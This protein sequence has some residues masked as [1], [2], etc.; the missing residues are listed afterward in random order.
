MH[1]L[2]R[3][4]SSCLAL[5]LSTRH[6]PERVRV[7]IVF[8]ISATNT[9]TARASFEA[10]AGV[11]PPAQDYNEYRLHSEATGTPLV[12]NWTLTCMGALLL[13]RLQF[14]KIQKRV[15][16]VATPHASGI[17]ITQSCS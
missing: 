7:E 1:V 17:L 14:Y 13:I 9:K 6:W 15:V 4:S 10:L 5:L 16:S 8:P 11:P 12:L 2:S 3:D